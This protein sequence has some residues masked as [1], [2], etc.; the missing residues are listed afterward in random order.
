M[1]KWNSSI[2]IIH[3]WTYSSMQVWIKITL[4]FKFQVQSSKLRLHVHAQTII[5]Y[6]YWFIFITFDDWK[7]LKSFHFLFSIFWKWKFIFGEILQV[8]EQSIMNH[9]QC[10]WHFGKVVINL[11]KRCSWFLWI[12]YNW[13]TRVAS[14]F[15]AFTLTC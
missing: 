14:L 7:P 1:K 15:V 9:S 10:Q 12:T 8:C 13:K 11:K 5:T 3:L 2:Q 4:N 6:F